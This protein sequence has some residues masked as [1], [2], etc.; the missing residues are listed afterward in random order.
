M[1]EQDK[2]APLLSMRLD[3]VTR[4]RLDQLAAHLGINRS[5]VVRLAVQRLYQAER[6]DRAG[7]SAPEKLAATA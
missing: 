3:D 1:M 2:K 6:P 4:A 5:S 7:E